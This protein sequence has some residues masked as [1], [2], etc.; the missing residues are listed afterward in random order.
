MGKHKRNRTRSCSRRRY[1]RSRSKSREHSPKRRKSGVDDSDLNLRLDNLERLIRTAINSSNKGSAAVRNKP[2]EQQNIIPEISVTVSPFNEGASTSSSTPV[3]VGGVG[4]TL[5]AREQ[6][7]AAGSEATGSAAAPSPILPT[8]GGIA[9]R[10]TITSEARPAAQTYSSTSFGAPTVCATDQGQMNKLLSGSENIPVFT[11][12]SLSDMS[13]QVWLN[14]LEALAKIFNWNERFLIYQ[15][16][17]KLAG[18]ARLWF[19]SQQEIDYT[20]EQWKYKI[21]SDFPEGRG[22]AL[23]LH[24]FVTV[25]R[26]NNENVLDFYYKKL[27]LGKKCDQPEHVITDVIIFTLNDPLL[28]AGARGAACRDTKSLLQ[29][30][31]DA[32]CDSNNANRSKASSVNYD[33]G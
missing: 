24:D 11:G 20:W 6:P 4:A 32:A 29:Y 30:L 19:N 13:A 27:S 15:M 31:T 23:K 3:Q 21:L 9:R 17:T 25:K 12:D 16:T 7:E 26:E 18:N 22:I 10:V 28:R 14:R 33:S 8:P 1:S 2:Q 5:S